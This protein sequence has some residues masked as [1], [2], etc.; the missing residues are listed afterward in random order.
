MAKR[1]KPRITEMVETLR[2]AGYRVETTRVYRKHTFEIEESTL[3][4]FFKAQVASGLMVKDAAS[5]AMADWIAK[6]AN[7]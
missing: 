2:A 4:A 5:E 1:P 3:V 6:R 7:K